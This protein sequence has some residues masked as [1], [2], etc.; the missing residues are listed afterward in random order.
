MLSQA[1]AGN[2]EVTPRFTDEAAVTVVC[3]TEGYPR[4]PRVGD[5]IDGLDEAAAVDGVHIY[6]AG[7]DS[8]ADGSL[9]TSGGRVLSVT[10]L[11]PDIS[12]ARSRAY[13]AVD[14][15]RWPGKHARRDIALAASHKEAT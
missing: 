9:V 1:A 6:R 4:S 7:V 15:I 10:A 2:I 3:A 13:H 11:G 8:A 14:L 12:E 5:V